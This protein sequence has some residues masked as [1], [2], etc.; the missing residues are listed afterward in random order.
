L[1]ADLAEQILDTLPFEAPVTLQHMVDKR[2]IKAA[3]DEG[4]RIPG[5]AFAEPRNTLARK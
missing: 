1:P 4:A 2:A 5:A 3:L